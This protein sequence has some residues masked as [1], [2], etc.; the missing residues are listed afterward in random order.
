MKCTQNYPEK[1][2]RCEV[3]GE[4]YIE[5]ADFILHDGMI[6]HLTDKDWAEILTQ[7]SDR[8][9]EIKYSPEEII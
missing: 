8:S 4:K 6:V 9:N 3:C 5:E 1:P 7:M 2:T